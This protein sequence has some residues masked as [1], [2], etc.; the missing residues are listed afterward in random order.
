[1]KRESLTPAERV[2]RAR[3]AAYAQHA[4]HDPRET[5]RPARA[6]FDQRFLDEVDPDR[7]LPAPERQ[8]RAAAARR[9]YF[10]RLAY[11]S[12]LKR[13]S[14]RDRLGAGAAGLRCGSCQVDPGRDC[15]SS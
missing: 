6:A 3:I 9:A 1:M 5:T 14:R 8:R 2:M 15:R 7:R 11:L 13:R 10:T 12:A 4:R